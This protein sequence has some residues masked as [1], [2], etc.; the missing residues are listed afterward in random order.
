[1]KKLAIICCYGLINNEGSEEE[2][3]GLKEY[4]KNVIKEIKSQ[5]NFLEA[6]VIS[7]G[8]T[9]TNIIQSEAQST[10]EFLLSELSFDITIPVIKENTSLKTYENIA[11]SALTARK[12][13]DQVDTVLIFCDEHRKTK[14]AVE[15][16]ILFQ[17]RF[18][19]EVKDFPRSD[20]HPNSNYELQTNK[21]LPMETSL[22]HFWQVKKLIDI[23]L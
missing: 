3:Q 20:T 23:S 6:I 15:A 19:V 12:Y 10:L 8:Y 17:D 2:I 22:D 14:V 11:F 4:Y 18:K 7:G 13:L 5:E 21:A 1:M 9:N 16:S